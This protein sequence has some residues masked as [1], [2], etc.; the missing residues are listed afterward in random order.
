VNLHHDEDSADKLMSP[1][2]DV[3]HEAN[4]DLLASLDFYGERVNAQRGASITIVPMS[5][6]PAVLHPAKNSSSTS[7]SE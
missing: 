7:A 6:I 2:L 1:S 5:G 3:P 4:V